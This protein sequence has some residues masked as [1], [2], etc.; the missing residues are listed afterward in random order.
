MKVLVTGGT[1]FIGQHLVEKLVS[2]GNKVCL[3]VRPTTD[4]KKTKQ[5]GLSLYVFRDNV[6]DLIK[7]M[8]REKFAGVIHLASLFLVNHKPQDVQNLIDSNVRLGTVVLESS[9]QSSTPWFIN[10]GTYSQHYNGHSYCPVNLYAATKQAFED[11]ARY[12]IETAPINFVTLKLYDT[13]GP[14]DTRPKIFNLWSKITNSGESLDMSPGEQI[15]DISYIDNVI[16]GYMQL[17]V[18]LSRDSGRK[19]NGQSFALKSNERMSLKRLAKTFE[20]V[21]KNKLNINWG[22]KSYR[23]REVMVPWKRDK[24]VPRWRPK[25]SLKEGIKRTF[26]AN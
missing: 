21:T 17:S 2:S 4:I 1:G 11:V 23:Q 12:Y 3:L 14:N 19:L 20:Q 25:V 7:F 8:K 13:F 10:T 18:L 6:D 9:V 5:K 24:T 26:N 22:G 15:M 16:D